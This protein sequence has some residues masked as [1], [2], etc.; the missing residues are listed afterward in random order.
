MNTSDLATTYAKAFPNARPWTAEEFADLLSQVGVTLVGDAQSFIL[1]RQIL[2]EVE[3]L[4]L[5]THPSVQRQGHAS[6]NLSTLLRTAQANGAKIIFLEVAS[7]NAAA[8]ALYE[9]AGFAEFGS[10][11]AYYARA[12]GPAI[13]ALI[14]Q[15]KLD[16]A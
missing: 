8:L 1:V 2:D 11:S 6:R 9:S 7:D 12:N 3:I 10:R 14:L 13:D 16:P 4:T 15:K 5:A